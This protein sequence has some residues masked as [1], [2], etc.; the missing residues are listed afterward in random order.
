MRKPSKPSIIVSM[1]LASTWNTI[2]LA[3]DV[4]WQRSRNMTRDNFTMSPLSCG[5]SNV[6]TSV[7]F[8]VHV[9]K[10]CHSWTYLVRIH[11]FL[12]QIEDCN[13]KN[14]RAIQCMQILRS[15]RAAAEA[16]VAS[17]AQYSDVTL[18][19]ATGRPERNTLDLCGYLFHHHFM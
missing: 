1:R 10:D 4:M 15:D 2:C 3:I 16:P 11:A 7:R 6:F 8:I 5:K 18:H 13:C 14:Q 17:V 19:T 9:C 12:Y